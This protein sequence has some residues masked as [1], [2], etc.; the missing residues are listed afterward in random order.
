LT[1][2]SR[3]LT[4]LRAARRLMTFNSL[5][6]LLLF[7]ATF[8]IYWQLPRMQ[9]NRWLLVVSY[10]FYGCWDYRFLALLLFATT[11]DYN[12]GLQI[13][14]SSEPRRKLRFLC[15][16]LGTNLGLLG[17][18]KYFDFFVHS[19]VDLLRTLGLDATDTRTLHIV[20]PVGISFYTFQTMS[21]TLDVYRGKTEPE[22]NFFDFAL[23]VAFFPQLVA[24]PIER[25]VDLLP[26]IHRERR[27][28]FERASSGLA[29]ATWG[30][31][32]KV[33]LADNIG[34][35][36]NPVFSGMQYASTLEICV[37]V[38]GFAFQIYYDFSGYTDIAR[39][40]ARLL[41][42]ELRRNFDKPYFAASPVEFWERWHMSLSAWFKDYLYFPL[43]MHYVRKSSSFFAQHKAHLVAMALIGLWHGAAFQF[44]LFGVYWGIAIIAYNL[45]KK[46]LVRIPRRARVIAHFGIVCG[47]FLLFRVEHLSD[48]RY[49]FS[50][51]AVPGVYLEWAGAL[52]ILAAFVAAHMLLEGHLARHN[53][54]DGAFW[55][56]LPHRRRLMAVALLSGMA[57]VLRATPVDFIYFRF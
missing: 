13:F 31:F 36:L 27:L 23:F 28:Q 55:M 1:R 37:A 38:V 5:A 11:V 6:F 39:G 46:R 35:R 10:F 29:L 7:F 2:A 52:G 48:I 40:V 50:N 57:I 20:L 16:G 8:A 9:Q 25:S 18:F 33:V 19:A 49:L 32:K 15:L 53:I 44:V 51:F 56:A 54:N 12:C 30:M 21:Y 17:F 4:L 3:D 24:G 45:T 34:K 47:A 26:Q 14:R 42:F 43:A 22:R 41:G